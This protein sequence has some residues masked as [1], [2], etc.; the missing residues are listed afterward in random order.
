METRRFDERYDAIVVGAGN[1]G[2]AAGAVLA[3]NGLKPL[4]LEKH[5][6]PVR[7]RLKLRTRRFEF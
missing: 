4:I 6:S 5:S 3:G 7:L 1:G 2:L